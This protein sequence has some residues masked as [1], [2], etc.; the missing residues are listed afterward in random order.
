MPFSEYQKTRY[1]ENYG[2]AC[3]FCGSDDITADFFDEES[4]E[5][6]RNVDCRGCERRWR[7]VYRL[8]TIEMLEDEDGKVV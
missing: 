6:W 2:L 3:P 5:A 7:E 4:G 8:T 1:R